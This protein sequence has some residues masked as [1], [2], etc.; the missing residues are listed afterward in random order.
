MYLAGCKIPPNRGPLLATFG[1]AQPGWRGSTRADLRAVDHL[2][3]GSRYLGS[4]AV[5]PAW[6]LDTRGLLRLLG[7]GGSHSAVPELC[8]ERGAGGKEIARPAQ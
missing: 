7:A 3:Q 5:A 1:P 2:P 6:L 4:S 8:P